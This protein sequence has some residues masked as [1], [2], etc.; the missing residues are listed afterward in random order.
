MHKLSGALLKETTTLTDQN[1]ATTASSTSVLVIS[2]VPTELELLISSLC[3]P[4]KNTDPV[5]Q[6]TSGQIDRQQLFCA[7]AGIG[8]TNAAA[9]TA[10]L[11]ERV[12]PQM[13]LNIGCG[14]AFAGSGLQVGDLAI[15]DHE[16]FADLGVIAPEGWLDLSDLGFAML[17]TAGDKY[18]NCIPL[19]E[20]LANK[21]LYHA[22]K[23]GIRA[24]AGIFAT[25]ASC[26]G[27]ALRGEELLQRYQPICENMEGAAVAAV[28]LRYNIPCIELRGISNLVED[29]D[30]TRWNIPLAVTVAQRAALSLLA[31]PGLP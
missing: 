6:V 15:A 5:W 3:N 21:A 31:E 1:L 12:R 27:T 25:V 13:V 26:S 17:A 28:C 22:Q 4:Q 9:A 16:I 23:A 8:T 24:K 20:A 18:Y 30:L 14:G 11:I 2:A 10:V 7:V 19:D 29:R